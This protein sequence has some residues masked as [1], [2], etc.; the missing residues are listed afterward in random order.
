MADEVEAFE[1]LWSDQAKSVKVIDFPEAARK[2]LWSSF[3]RTTGSPRQNQRG[4]RSS[5]EVV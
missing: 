1:R 5:F 2:K 4:H 3:R